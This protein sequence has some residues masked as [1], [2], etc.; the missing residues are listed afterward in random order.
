MTRR[1][2]SAIPAALAAALALAAPGPAAALDLILR[3][4]FHFPRAA[5]LEWDPVLCALWVAVEGPQ[6]FL[7]T[8][9]GRELR[10]LEPGMRSIR[11]LAV[12]REGLLLA[13]G[14]GGFQRMTREGALVGEPFRLAPGLYDI[15]GIHRAPDGS[16]LVVEDDE[17]RILRV[18][19][20]GTIAMELWGGRLSPALEEPQGVARDPLTGNI[21][22][23]DDNEGLNA[24]VEMTPE[25][26]I[27][28]VT[29]LS[30]WGFDAEGVAVHA[31]SGTLFIGFDSGERI[32]VFD[33][34]PTASA[35]DAAAFGAEVDA[36]PECPVS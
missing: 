1:L 13:D 4:S 29:P 16:Y 14:L 2:S 15:E 24:L 23:V 9:G 7:I 17:A 10:R 18:A 6:I 30:P 11:A 32:A 27:L 34:L 20:D 35:I 33:Y 19:P 36:A 5:S 28:S 21:L 25:G 12:E 31:P 26:T 3:D 8:P 22:V